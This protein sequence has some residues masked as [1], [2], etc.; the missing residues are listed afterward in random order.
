MYPDIYQYQ[1]G[2]VIGKINVKTT[3]ISESDEYYKGGYDTTKEKS[4]ISDNSKGKAYHQ[5]GNSLSDKLTVKQT[6]YNIKVNNTNYGD[7]SKVLD[8]DNYWVASRSSHCYSS[9]VGFGLRYKGGAGGID[10]ECM[11]K[12]ERDLYYNNSNRH[13]LRPVVQLESNVQIE[14]TKNASYTFSQFKHQIT[15][16]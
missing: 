1:R 10:S 5:V 12:S 15:K 4:M 14:V 6:Y 16:Y 9:L 2:T 3:G 11:L 13:Y 8:K 7:G